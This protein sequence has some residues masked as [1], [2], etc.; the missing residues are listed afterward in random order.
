MIRDSRVRVAALCA[1]CAVAACKATTTKSETEAK[2]DSTK[3][4]QKGDFDR[5]DAA[6]SGL[7][8]SG[9]SPALRT[10][11]EAVLTKAK[12][13][14]DENV[15]VTLSESPKALQAT[16]TV[17]WVH[18]PEVSKLTG[19]LD[20][21]GDPID[22]AILCTKLVENLLEPLTESR[23]KAS[24]PPKK[25][26][27]AIAVAVGNS[28]ACSHHADGDVRCWGGVGIIPVNPGS[29][30]SV[31]Q[32]VA[33]GNHACARRMDGTV[34]CWGYLDDQ[35]NRVPD[36]RQVC[37]VDG[38]KAL[39]IDS[40]DGCVVD[41]EGAVRCWEHA[42]AAFAPC[43]GEPKLLEV[44]GVENATDVSVEGSA[45]CALV[46]GGTV[47]CWH[48]AENGITP[49]DEVR[50]KV[51]RLEGPCIIDEAGAVECRGKRTA[52]GYEW[53]AYADVK[54]TE[55]VSFQRVG[56]RGFGCAVLS[57]KKL[58]CWGGNDHGQLGIGD[59]KPRSAPAAVPLKDVTH[60][61]TG[62][63][64][65]CA[66]AGGQAHCWGLGQSGLIQSK[67]DVLSPKAI[68]YTL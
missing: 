61:D 59:R 57:G 22:G 1:G 63:F 67:D 2:W 46:E 32:I 44:D 16:V 54:G 12:L 45:N 60:V 6:K 15:D 53:D 30:G 27:P 35:M 19:T 40:R 64:R 37:G 3:V 62:L 24:S 25:P 9:A 34:A 31:Q 68:R 11:C 23:K 52:D 29:L 58:H 10:D 39:S 65:A 14:T 28:I 66:V 38:A 21:S 47:R 5:F 41:H 8:V 55:Q 50:T 13:G 26:A 7:R 49:L 33:A 51:A 17:E 56:Q 43:E 4:S 18:Y 42:D 20:L 48:F 36:P